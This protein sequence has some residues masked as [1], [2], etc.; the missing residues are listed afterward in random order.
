[1]SPAQA[2]RLGELWL[3]S[4]FTA[5]LWLHWRTRLDALGTMKM[6]V[7]FGGPLIGEK[8][9]A[10]MFED[11]DADDGHLP[12][13]AMLAAATQWVVALDLPTSRGELWSGPPIREH[14][15]I[16]VEQ[17]APC[18]PDQVPRRLV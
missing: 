1:M 13:I 4:T 18:E 3:I 11:D 2:G 15:R 10:Q 7:A 8:E 14:R 5:T 12:T 6:A 9:A 17:A 16:A